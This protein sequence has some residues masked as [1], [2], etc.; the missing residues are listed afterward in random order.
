MTDS[1]QSLVPDTRR[2]LSELAE[3]NTRDWFLSQKPRY[4]AELK[5]PAEH[6]LAQVAADLEKLTGKPAKPKLF[7]AN[8][9]VR[10]SKDKPPY[11]THL[12]MLW[13]TENEA[14]QPMGWF[15]GIGLD[16]LSVGAGLM[17]FEKA[18]LT[19][20]RALIDGPLGSDLIA[21][22]EML[23]DQG[24]RVTEPELKRVPPP[25]AKD[26]PRSE[27]LRR[28]GLSAW[29]DHQPGAM[30]APVK[31]VMADFAAL[32]PLTQKLSQ[33]I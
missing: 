9:D 5:R 1:F 3:N 20:W 8:R 16:H 10:F 4:E 2:F 23:R 17:G 31:I 25:Y 13:T 6:L 27:Y 12:H 30:K 29:R 21:E 22:A 28:K 11:H 19:H 7:R 32:L 18:T 26:H 33:V 24:F 15:F 14:R